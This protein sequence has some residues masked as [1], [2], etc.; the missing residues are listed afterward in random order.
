MKKENQ[1]KK[2]KKDV[3]AFFFCFLVGD[4]YKI[5]GAEIEI[6]DIINQ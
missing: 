2:M 4:I 5:N 1:N 3:K 6:V